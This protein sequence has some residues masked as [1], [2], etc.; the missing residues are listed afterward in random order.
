[1]TASNA[2]GTYNGPVNVSLSASA[3]AGLNVANTYYIVD[4]GSEQT[5]TEPFNVT[6]AGEHTVK[7]WSTDSAGLVEAADTKIFTIASGP[8]LYSISGK[9]TDSSGDAIANANI[10]VTNSVTGANAGNVVSDSSGNYSLTVLGGVYDIHVVPLIT[11]GF[12]SAIALQQNVSVNKTINFILTPIGIVTLSG[13]I[14]GPLGNP[15][16]NQDVALRTADG[17][18]QM[19]TTDISGKYSLQVPSGNY[20]LSISG[21]A[22]NASLKAPQKYTLL[23]KSYQITES[24]VLDITVPAKKVTVHVQDEAGEPMSGIE[25]KTSRSWRLYWLDNDRWTLYRGKYN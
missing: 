19:T 22:N 8:V 5:Y 13:H 11:S 16:P 15:L 21:N 17:F 20:D 25:L 2:D 14:Y 10:S 23:V 4:G 7:Y 1:M 24:T 18:F 12:T 6:G 3:S 9:I